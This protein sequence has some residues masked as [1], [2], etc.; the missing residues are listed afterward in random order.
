[1]LTKGHDCLSGQGPELTGC[2]HD[3]VAQAATS[4]TTGQSKAHSSKLADRDQA[5]PPQRKGGSPAKVPEPSLPPELA[6][7]F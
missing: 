1:V 7:G 2:N 5:I 3:T 6:C 4:L